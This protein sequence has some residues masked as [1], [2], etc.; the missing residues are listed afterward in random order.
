MLTKLLKHE[1]KATSRVLVPVF[2]IAFIFTFLNRIVLGFDIF[3]G[4]FTFIPGLTLAG[5][6]ISL[7]A[8]LVVTYVV[9]IIRFRS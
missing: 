8:V 2:L 6:A 9:L 1:L 3:H 7:I 4:V 5:Y